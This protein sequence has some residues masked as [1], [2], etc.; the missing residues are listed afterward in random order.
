[1]QTQNTRQLNNLKNM[2]SYYSLLNWYLKHFTMNKWQRKKKKIK[3][4]HKKPTNPCCILQKHLL[5]GPFHTWGRSSV[6]AIQLLAG[7]FQPPLAA[8]KGLKTPTK[9]R[10]S[11]S[12]ATLPH[13]FLAPSTLK[14]LLAG[15]FP[16]PASALLHCERQQWLFQGSLQAPFFSDVAPAKHPSVK[17]V[18]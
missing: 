12:I 9:H 15:V 6:G 5:Y 8:E 4:I 18:L 3:K 14:M 11:G 1:M 7:R 17:V 13:W 16:H 2:L 10:C